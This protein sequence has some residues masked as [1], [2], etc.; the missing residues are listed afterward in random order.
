MFELTINDK[1]YQFRFGMGFLREVNKSLATDIDGIK[2]AKKNI[3]LQFSLA[4][5]MD[6]D[7][8]TLVEFLDIA[9][10]SEKPRITRKELDAYIENSDTDVDTLIDDL[11]D[12]FRE[13]NTTKKEM[14]ALDE[15]AAQNEEK[16]E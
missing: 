9:N 15:L 10:K 1:V 11:L 16:A 3:G 2:G 6:R 7:L 8:E 5:L 13:N 4:L 14:E 12:F